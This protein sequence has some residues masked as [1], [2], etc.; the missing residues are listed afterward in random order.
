MFEI[1]RRMTSMERKFEKT[2]SELTSKLEKTTT[3]LEN[4]ESKTAHEFVEIK[5]SFASS[6]PH[7]SSAGNILPPGWT[8]HNDAK[9]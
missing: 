7:M 9:V 4:H 1:M 5:S 3:K 2:S 6:I 8:Q